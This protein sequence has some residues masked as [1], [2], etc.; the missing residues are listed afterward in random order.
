MFSTKIFPMGNHST[1]RKKSVENHIKYLRSWH[2][3]VSL[4]HSK[5]RW[6]WPSQ[7]PSSALRCS[8]V[9]TRK[10]ITTP[11]GELKRSLWF[12]IIKTKMES[13][14][15][16]SSHVWLYDDWGKRLLILTQKANSPNSL[17]GLISTRP[18][19]MKANSQKKEKFLITVI[20]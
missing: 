9:N 15:S 3:A 4:T 8:L 18:E 20:L 7:M 16:L 14:S 1:L 5:R 12:V 19:E 17:K 6:Q 11:G 10:R 2:I 13:L